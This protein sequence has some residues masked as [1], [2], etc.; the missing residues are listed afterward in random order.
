MCLKSPKTFDNFFKD[1][2]KIK[3]DL[4][5]IILELKIKKK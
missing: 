2:I 5:K 1:I 4:K 3:N